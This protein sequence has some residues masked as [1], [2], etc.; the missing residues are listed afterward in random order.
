[1]KRTQRAV[2]ATVPLALALSLAACSSDDDSAS[3]AAA[4]EVS[5]PTVPYTTPGEGIS[6]GHDDQ[7]I[8]DTIPEPV[9]V[10]EIQPASENDLLAVL[11]TPGGLEIGVNV[12]D[13]VTGVVVKGQEQQDQYY[14]RE[15]DKPEVT[16]LNVTLPFN[17][18]T[19]EYQIEQAKNGQDTISLFG[20]T[21]P[22]ILGILGVILLIVGFVLG[23]RGGGNRRPATATGGPA[24]AGPATTTV[25]PA[26]SAG[27]QHDHTD[28][29]TEVIP[30]QTDPN[31]QQRDWTTDQTQE[32][33]RTDLR[34]PPT[35]E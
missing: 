9:H 16:V 3:S 28:D 13:P 17:E 14:A 1:M 30:R 8:G 7:E 20:R 33:P 6:L 34:K 27:A 4:G 31:A 24:P 21:L 2:A 25:R 26:H 12:L 29:R 15:A 5:Y 19:I 32:I 35:Q 11:R 22:I 18:E 10:S 23:L